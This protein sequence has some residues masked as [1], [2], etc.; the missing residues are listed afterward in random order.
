MKFARSSRISLL[1]LGLVAL[2]MPLAACTNN[3]GVQNTPAEPRKN[4]T[5]NMAAAPDT[6]TQAVAQVYADTLEHLGYTV[7]RTDST[8]A[9]YQQVAHGKADLAIDV[10]PKALALVPNGVELRGEDKILSLEEAS[11]LVSRINQGDLDFTAAPLSPA[12]AGKVLVLSAAEAVEYK[13]ESVPTF[14]AA[15]QELDIVAEDRPTPAFTEALQ[16]AGCAH[17]EIVTEKNSELPSTLRTATNQAVVL[18]AQDALIG[19]E[20]FSIV[21]GSAK[22]F[23]AAPYLPLMGAKVE[24]QALQGVKD[25]TRQLSQESVIGLNRMVSGPDALPAKEAAKRW[26]WLIDN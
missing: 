20:G 22:L 14:A 23:D 26:K 21:E 7:K 24:G 17:P 16:A 4:I 11:S 18:S 15:C 13:V 8:D 5:L 1:S 25:L 12:N 10:A 3:G 2:A 19:D 6:T 9:P